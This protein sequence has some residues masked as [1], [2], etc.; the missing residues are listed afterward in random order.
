MASISITTHS[1]AMQ[2]KDDE[3]AVVLGSPSPT[4]SSSR[5]FPSPLYLPLQLADPDNATACSG[6]SL[7]WN[8]FPEYTGLVT[9]FVAGWQPLGS[10]TAAIPVNYMSPTFRTLAVNI[11]SHFHNFTWDA[12]DVHEGWYYINITETVPQTGISARSAPFFVESDPNATC[13]EHDSFNTYA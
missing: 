9:L 3:V 12:V 10:A 7:F 13:L 2:E 5:N 8:Y 4:S 11:P 1:G 6:L